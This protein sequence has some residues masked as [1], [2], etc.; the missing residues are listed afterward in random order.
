MSEQSIENYINEVLTG[1]EQKNALDFVAYLRASE[2]L[3]ERGGGYWEDKLYWYIKFK[4]EYVCYIL[5]GSEEK[6]GPGPWII[7]SDDSGSNW[8]TNFPLDEHMKKIAWKNV[9]ICGNCGGC[10]NRGYTRKTKTIFGKEFN[11]V[12][13]TTFSF[14]DP[15]VEELEFMKKMVELRKND[16]LKN[17]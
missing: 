1:N 6:P 8:F 10:D 9:S 13:L 17:I 4:N 11:N 15:D 5:I 7:W 3:F 12:C 2:M 16:I 14:T